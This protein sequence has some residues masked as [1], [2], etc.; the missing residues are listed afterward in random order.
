MSGNRIAPAAL[1]E[2]LKDGDE[3]ALLDVR[4]E[5]AFGRG[6]LLLAINQPLSRIEF[7]IRKFVPRSSTRIVLCD[8]D[9]GA[10]ARALPVLEAAG[11]TD[12]NVLDGG[13]AAWS[14]AGFELFDGT[15]VLEHAFGLFIADEYE[16]PLVSAQELREKLDAGENLVILDSR[17]SSEFQ[18]G[19]LPGSINLPLCEEVYRIHDVVTDQQTQIVTLCAGVTRGTLL[20]QSLINAG[21]ANPI[22][23]LPDGSKGWYA[24]GESLDQEMSQTM[25]DRSEAA[26]AWSAQ[27]PKQSSERFVARRI[28]PAEL[29]E[30]RSESES[31][32]LY[33]V[34]IRSREEYDEGHLPD[35]IW[36][37]GG[38][39]VGFTQDYLATRNARLCL[40]DNDCLRAE[41]VASWMLQI[42]WP[43]VVALDGG[44]AGHELVTETP[45]P[46]VPELE[47]VQAPTISPNDLAERIKAST[48][49]VID[50]AR[51][52][53][54][55]GGH[56]PGAW[57]MNRS[58][59]P[60]LVGR[61]PAADCYVATSS[62]GEAGKLAAAALAILVDTPVMVLEGGTAAWRDANLEVTT[63]LLRPI[64]ELDD[65]Y[66]DF[67]ERPGDDT[68]TKK[69]ACRRTSAW[70]GRLRTQY[71]N[72]STLPFKT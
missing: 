13:V 1:E 49:V 45:P 36:V 26:I 3:I 16:T 55:I 21:V 61:L 10:V 27:A 4:E 12:L 34:D 15:Y 9:D 47:K 51:S 68:A 40:V 35:A 43:E 19:C 8:E 41:L 56:I 60:R 18:S 44:I 31:R 28:S 2:M 54:H 63:G 66:T 25:T 48:A 29:D 30:W 50:F 22:M 23:F 71:R 11:Y 5:N 6:H 17:P 20:A 42:G 38:Q 7:T 53:Q 59:L 52:V 32:T 69:A 58:S 33:L 72:D 70:R 65:T 67:A 24:S 62:S 46:S 14:D 57:W 64:G 39:L 37:P